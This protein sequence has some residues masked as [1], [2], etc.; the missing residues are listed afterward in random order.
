MD[1]IDKHC[2]IT[3]MGLSVA[4]RAVRK[5]NKIYSFVS[6]KTLEKNKIE[7]NSFI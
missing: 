7:E 6:K 3:L 2:I 1:S 5:Q 4:F